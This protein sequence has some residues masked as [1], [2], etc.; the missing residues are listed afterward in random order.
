MVLALAP[1]AALSWL[2]GEPEAMAV[3]RVSWMVLG[4]VNAAL[5]ALV[6]RP[7]SRGAGLVAGLFYALSL[8]AA[9]TE[10]TTLLEPPATTVL[11]SATVATRLLGSAEGI[12][13]RHYLMAG[14]L[15]GISPVLKIWGV[16]AVLVV[17]VA[18][19]ARRGRRPGLLTLSA[20][21][22]FCALANLPFFLASPAEMW[23][24]V[25]VA[26]LGRRR[27]DERVAERLEDVLGVR[28]WTGG[29]GH[30]SVPIVIMLAVV[31]PA[32]VICL[33]SSKLRVIAALMITS[34]ILVMTTPMWFLHYAGLTAAPMALTVGG[35]LS[36]MT[37]WSRSR[38]GWS[39]LITAA[40]VGGTLLL[41]VPMGRV[42]LGNRSFP[43]ERLRAGLSGHGGC[44]T[45]D[46]P[47][48]AIQLDAL[49][50]TIGRNCTYVVDLGGYSYYLIDSPYHLKSRRKNLDWQMVALDYYRSGDAVLSVRFS[51]NSGYSPETAYIVDTWQ[52]LAA[53]NGYV[54]RRPDRPVN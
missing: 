47:M 40:A 12:Q 50:E 30:W 42:D 35:G 43:A 36:V 22:W 51:T 13:P 19:A 34:G 9:Y 5:C 28:E 48:A 23:R 33:A 27:A 7:V 8:G 11:L 37:A 20:A 2:I 15:L 3:A 18:I 53:A 41:G 14:I 52:P 26:Q 32:T 16:V 38:R 39:A 54:I 45:T 4:S 44:L 21:V 17:V 10:H 1:F 24:M 6:L 46:W 25:V 29:S 31:V 49:Q